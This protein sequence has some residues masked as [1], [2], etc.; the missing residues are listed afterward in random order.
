VAKEIY[1]WYFGGRKDVGEMPPVVKPSV[2]PKAPVTPV[3]P[4]P[5]APVPAQPAAPASSPVVP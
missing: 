1:R 4:P 2:E 5:T 3:T